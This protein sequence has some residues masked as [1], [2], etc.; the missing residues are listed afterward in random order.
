MMGPSL[1]GAPFHEETVGDSAKHAKYPHPVVTLNPAAVVIVGDVQTLVQ[2]ALN[3]PT[4]PIQVQ[5]SLGLEFSTGRAGDQGHLFIFSPFGLA[6]EARCLCRHG[7]A[8]VLRRDSRRADHTVF[9]SPFV[10]LLR[11][12]FCWRRLVRGGNPLGERILF[13]RCWP[14]AWADCF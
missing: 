14:E 7:K 1:S 10:V 12:S 5:P 9:R 3:T 8:H 13:F 2:P 11:A 4:R 6:Q